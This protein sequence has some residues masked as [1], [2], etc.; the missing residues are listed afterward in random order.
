MTTSAPLYRFGRL[1]RKY[2]PAIPQFEA[3]MINKLFS[4]PTKVD[5]TG[6]IIDG[7]FGMMRNGPSGN[8]PPLNDCTCA[9][10]YHARQIWTLNASNNMVTE[11]DSNVI[12]LYSAACGYD[13]TKHEDPGG[14]ESDVL[15]YLY[16]TGAPTSQDGTVFDK[17]H[18]YV[19]VDHRNRALVKL[20]IYQC[21]VAYIGFQ[22]TEYV[23]FGNR[24]WDYVP[25]AIV[26]SEGHAVV[27][28]GYDESGTTAISW[29]QRYTVTWDFIE[30]QVDEIYGIVDTAW[31]NST[32]KTPAGLTLDELE[33][34]M[35][36]LKA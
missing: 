19:E 16:N 32:G 10:Y 14:A 1:P 6:D 28:A 17:I 11:P 8:F 13:P 34:L 18:G 30:N 7:A 23:N 24:T 12:K 2:D 5:Y 31:V 21:G 29:G 33:Q 25:G 4:T 9:A 20:I 3:M 26:G 15:N 27:L 35:L 22:V 36:P